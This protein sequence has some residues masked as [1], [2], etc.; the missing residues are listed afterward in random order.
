MALKEAAYREKI[1]LYLG[2]NLGKK[3]TGNRISTDLGLFYSLVHKTIKDLEREGILH[4][5]K[6]GNYK[7][8]SLSLEKHRTILE[9]ALLS[10]R[11]MEENEREGRIDRKASDFIRK[12]AG[13]RDVLSA[14]MLADR[15]I[16]FSNRSTT[17]LEILSK[18]FDAGKEIHIVKHEDA[19]RFSDEE[20]MMP[21]LLDGIVLCGYENFWRM[22]S[23][24][25]HK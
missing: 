20:G 6:V 17:H 8:I 11:L 19:G 25:A 23:E 7:L 24:N 13:E 9:L 15:I 16:I 10:H 22:V 3:I 2:R 21:R 14:V 4:T 18:T 5:E 12:I 1:L